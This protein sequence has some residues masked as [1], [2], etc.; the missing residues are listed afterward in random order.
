MKTLEILDKLKNVT[1]RNGK[2][3]ARC[4]A[5]DDRHNS[6]SIA[7]GEDGRTLLYCHAGCTVEDIVAAMGLSINDLFCS[8][9]AEQQINN[10]NNPEV[11]IY[12]YPNG[13]QKLRFP[14]KQFRWRRPDGNGGWIYNRQGIPRS[15]YIAGE[16]MDKVIIT[17]GEKDADNLHSLLG[18]NAVSGEDGAG[19]GKWHN[20]Y[21]EQ[22]RGLD[23]YIVN[24]ND[25]VGRAYANDVVSALRDAEISARHLD[26]STIWPDIPEHGDISDFISAVGSA[27]AKR[28]VGMML[29]NSTTNASIMKSH[30]ADFLL[31]SIK[32]LADIDEK[33]VAWLVPGWIPAAHI[34]LLAA[35]GGAGKTTIWCDIIAA[36]SSGTLC[37]IDPPN[38]ARAPRKVIFVSA[39]DSVEKK[40]KKTLRTFGADLHNI[41]TI[42]SSTDKGESLRKLKFGSAKLEEI[43]RYY[44]PALCVLDPVQGFIPPQVN[45]G[46]RNAMRDCLAPLITLGEETETAFLIVAHTNKRH[47]ASGRDRISDSADLWD[48]S[49]SVMMVGH[50]SELDIRYL[51]NEKNNYTAMRDTVLFSIDNNGKPQLEGTTWKRDKDYRSEAINNRSASRRDECKEWIIRELETC[52]DIMPSKLLE[53]QASRV[54]YKQATLRRAKEELRNNG[55]IV[56]NQKGHGSDKIWYVERVKSQ[57]MNK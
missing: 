27:E 29:A 3:S 52:G 41:I 6:L 51:S 57:I 44:R 48:I 18:Y 23:V 25:D 11:T 7:L 49:R 19:P 16:L 26:L 37:I 43:I 50:T 5:H 15:L 12:Q 55:S 14:G 34:T 8:R 4:P 13:A 39:E 42:D 56:Y 10:S 30:S 33:D 17:E 22:L 46:S 32:C 31:P 35:D 24:D 2:W 28:L 54:G 1:G 36:I 21:T 45:M 40:L 20:E 53:S 38:H 47:T 9:Q